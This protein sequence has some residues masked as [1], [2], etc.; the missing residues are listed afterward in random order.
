MKNLIAVF[1]LIVLLIVLVP[2]GLEATTL[3]LSYVSRTAASHLRRSRYR[4]T[5]L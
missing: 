5:R 2:A 3:S 1:R 4:R